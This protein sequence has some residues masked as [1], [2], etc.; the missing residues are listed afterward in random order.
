M[1]STGSDVVSVYKS[2]CPVS[3][4]PRYYHLSLRPWILQYF[5]ASKGVLARQC[6]W[7]ISE[8]R[9]LHCAALHDASP[10]L[11]D[12]ESARNAA[13]RSGPNDAP[14]TLYG[15]TCTKSLMD[16]AP[17]LYQTGANMVASFLPSLK[18]DISP[19]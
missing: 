9:D 12:T 2:C 6:K 14:A 18:M 3:I 4:D 19:S 17:D 8:A 11:P 15:F 1:N 7:T 5:A 13:L 16:D 10:T